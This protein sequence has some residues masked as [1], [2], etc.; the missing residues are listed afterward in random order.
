[1]REIILDNLERYIFGTALVV[2]IGM[3]AYVVGFASGSRS[4][5]AI[6]A[7]AGRAQAICGAIVQ[8]SRAG[9]AVTVSVVDRMAMWNERAEGAHVPDG[10]HPP[11]AG[12]TAASQ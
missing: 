4:A 12:A 8:D 7:E 3:V 9:L 6:A 10:V 11:R 2:S 5:A 1:M